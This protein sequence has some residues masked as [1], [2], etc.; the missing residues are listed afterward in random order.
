LTSTNAETAI[1]SE[2]MW[3]MDSHSSFLSE[4]MHLKCEL[5][6]SDAA[7]STQRDEVMQSMLLFKF[8]NELMR[9][10]QPGDTNPGPSTPNPHLLLIL[11]KI[12][13]SSP[14]YYDIFC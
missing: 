7:I 13:W 12:T 10:K 6:E 2:K 1:Q 11:P 14:C 5:L 8:S 3:S 4:I 9:A